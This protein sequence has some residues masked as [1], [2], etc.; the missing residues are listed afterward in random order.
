MAG[1]R[2]IGSAAAG[3]ALAGV[4]AYDV[5][6]R[7]HAILRNFPVVGHFRYVLEEVGP[8]LR[9]YIV[10]SND[11][12]RPFSRDQRRWVYASSKKEINT[13]GFGTDN[14]LEN[15]DGLLI[16]KQAAFPAA[17]PQKETTGS[18]PEYL[19][20]VAKV[21]GA[22]H[23]R[24]HAFRPQSVVNI[25]GMSYG[26]LSPPA[27]EALNR[28]AKLAPCLHNTGEGGLAPAHKHGGELV[29][30]IGTGYFG[31]RGDDG[32]FS[33]E[34]LL[35]R[36]SEAPVRAVEIKLSQGAK[37]GL[38]GMLPGCKVTPEI[39][40]IRGVPVGE[41]CVSPARHTAFGD[42]DGL[43]EFVE[44]IAEATGLPVGIKSAVGRMEFWS[45][46]AARM[47]ATGTGPDYIAVD[48]A[49]GG[50]GAA[51]LTF[52][53]HV[54]MPF[55]IAFSRV[56]GTFAEAGIA[57]DVV[58]VGAGRLG[59][60][61]T[62]LFAFALG[63]DMVSVAREPMLAIGCIQAQRCHTGTCPTG[64]ATQNRWLMRGLDPELKSARAANYVRALRGE[65]LALS[66]SC[67]VRHPALMTPDHVE[68][69]SDR[70]RT[71]GLEEVFGYDPAWRQLTPQRAQEIESLVGPPA[72]I[73][74]PGPEGG[75]V[76]GDEADT[77]EHE[78]EL[79]G[80]SG[81]A[82]MAAGGD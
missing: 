21:L 32:R 51:P 33:L 35:A 55:K 41:D 15:V 17:P 25:S 24:R 26:S 7:R 34:R 49:E 43:I 29:F 50:T 61:D 82:G 40:A 31:C 69:V 28:G 60:P 70:F 64:V 30:Q 57:E 20:P 36:I 14:D 27:V 48:G 37:P 62:A 72:G 9:Q 74:E 8:E 59:L 6:Q 16:L 44:T 78:Q 12:E 54:A 79:A 77:G 58:F 10:T 63:C 76:A 46:L 13:F 5:L 22:S 80:A 75:P 52:S 47:A 71:A 66:R 68:I 67:G 39:A 65:L 53:D 81:G 3:A 45:E 4:A 42:V 19:L 23:G 73:G 2:R 1:L 38:G 11:E 18:A 56:Y